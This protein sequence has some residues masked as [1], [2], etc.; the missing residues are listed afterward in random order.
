[1]C[2][3]ACNPGQH[4]A[5][6]VRVCVRFFLSSLTASFCFCPTFCS[7]LLAQNIIT[8]LAI[9][10]KRI[11]QRI[12]ICRGLTD[13]H[14]ILSSVIHW[15]INL[16]RTKLGINALPSPAPPPPKYASAKKPATNGAWENARTG[17]KW[18]GPFKSVRLQ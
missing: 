1:M 15:E 10:L 3:G 18:F 5:L 9:H 2:S 12:K 13:F 16:P 11:R 4:G 17:H 14:S 6:C 8:G 7:S